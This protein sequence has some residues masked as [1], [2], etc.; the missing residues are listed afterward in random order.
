MTFEQFQEA[1][2]KMSPAE[3]EAKI[4]EARKMCICGGCPTYVGTGDKK[5]AFCATQKSEIIKKEKGCICPACPVQKNMALRWDY[6][7][8]RGCAG[9]QAGM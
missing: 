7:C 8:T 4:E 5:L 2:N 9:E 3:L 6:Y 1:M